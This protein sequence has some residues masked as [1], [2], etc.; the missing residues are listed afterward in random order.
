MPTSYLFPGDRVVLH[1][2]SQ[3]EIHLSGR[4]DRTFLTP[5]R[6][7][8]Y[9]ADYAA[10]FRERA[11][12]P[13][14]GDDQFDRLHAELVKKV[15]GLQ[16][17]LPVHHRLVVSLEERPTSC[18]SH[19]L[20]DL[21]VP[22]IRVVDEVP[23]EGVYHFRYTNQVVVAFF[24]AP[25]LWDELTLSLRFRVHRDPDIDDPLIVDFM[26]L[27]AQDLPA[28]PRAKDTERIRIAHQGCIYEVDRFCPHQGGDLGNA[29]IIDGLLVCARHGWS[30][31]LEN[32]GSCT[33]S[34]ASINAI[35]ID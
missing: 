10:R 21:T 11:L 28:Y 13:P 5:D 16:Q 8:A 29:S 27:E 12:L 7:R 30:F 22:D 31:D 32:G 15:E 9:L 18:S 35:R 17:P 34:N 24:S 26:R 4:Y 14:A 3:P 25:I 1:S 33:S 6:K 2:G 20:I 23:T 19:I